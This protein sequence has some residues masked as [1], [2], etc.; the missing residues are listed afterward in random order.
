M[1]A[2]ITLTG[3]K[4]LLERFKSLSSRQMKAVHRNVLNRS[5]NKIAS[6]AKSNLGRTN[7]RLRNWKIRIKDGSYSTVDM[8]KDIFRSVWKSAEGG[9]VGVRP[10]GALKWFETG[11]TGRKTKKGHYRGAITGLR[12]FKQAMA[13]N[14]KKVEQDINNEL[15]KEINKRFYK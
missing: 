2:K 4:E 12:F 8:N 13:D 3:Q 14:A 10:R 9:T 7:P 15:A 6:A 11:T 5:L 1:S